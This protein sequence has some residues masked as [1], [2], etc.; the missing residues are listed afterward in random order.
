MQIKAKINRLHCG[1]LSED[2]NTLITQSNQ[3][4]LS[5]IY[6]RHQ[7]DKSFFFPLVDVFFSSSSSRLYEHFGPL[8]IYLVREKKKK[9]H[10]FGTKTI[11]R[12]DDDPRE[13]HSPCQI[14]SNWNVEQ[15]I[16]SNLFAFGMCLC[17]VERYLHEQYVCVYVPVM[18][19]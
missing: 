1:I 10:Q 9:T 7:C 5:G 19:V 14:S 3:T 13:M 6:T 2:D 4:L 12:H 16:K 18:L 8:E 17:R 15:E 11:L